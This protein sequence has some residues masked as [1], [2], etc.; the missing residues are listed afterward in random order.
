MSK[1]VLF[2]NEARK[3]IRIGIDTSCNAV[4]STLGP[5]GRNAFLDNTLEPEITNDGVSIAHSVRLED[6]IENMGCWL[7]DNTL[8]K[9]FDD[10][11]D[12]T[13]LTATLFQAFLDECEKRPENPMLIR[14]ELMDYSER[15]LEHIQDNSVK[16][17]DKQIFDIAKTA[18][19]SEEIGNLISE[20]MAEAGKNSA[21]YLEDNYNPYLDYE[22]VKG[23]QTKVGWAH[24]VWVNNKEN[25]SVE[26][27]D[28]H[29]LASDRRI[30]NIAEIG[31]LLQELQA[32]GTQTLVLLVNDMDNP[33]LG[34]LVMAKKMG[35]AS[36]VVVK[37]RGHD[38]EDMAV[39]C[40]ATLVSE[41]SGIKLNEIKIE[42]LGRAKKIIIGEKTTMIISNDSTIKTE[43][44]KNLRL[45]AESTKN[46]YEAQALNKRA[47]AIEGIIVKI[48]VGG[49]TDA[50]R[51][52]LKKKVLNA[53]NSTKSAM[54]EGIVE[55]GGMCLY[56]IS[57]KIKGKS[58]AEDIIRSALRAPLKTIIENAGE[59]YA[60]IVKGMPPKKG[61]DAEQDKYVDMFKAGIVDSAMSVRCAFINSLTN[62]ATFITTNVAVADKNNTNETTLK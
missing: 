32:E 20:I 9:T 47:E 23:L 42:H 4:K 46:M 36:M 15:V 6:K 35:G 50:E 2:G 27:E 43:G 30:S 59:D 38:L 22:I 17:K 34:S 11:G 56:R 1:Q 49:Y 48:K 29:I 28:V 18:G 58:I 7:V 45:R 5:R 24:N 26:L 53:V 10:A 12:N 37:V 33:A 19:E 8:S 54:Q 25:N 14:K 13:T 55:G 60:R 39:A 31:K 62:V 3:K 51:G 52:Y 21:V 44:I 61:Y 40:G 41:A 16:I 57:N